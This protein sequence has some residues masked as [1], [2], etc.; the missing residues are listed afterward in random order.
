VSKG[1]TV[2][3]SGYLALSNITTYTGTWNDASIA[4][5]SNVDHAN[6]ADW[7]ASV[8]MGT[9]EVIERKTLATNAASISFLNVDPTYKYLKIIWSGCSSTT[10]NRD[11]QMTLN[12]I[13]VGYQR[14]TSK[15][16]G[17]TNTDSQG[18]NETSMVF[19]SALGGNA[20]Y[21]SGGEI[22][23][24]NPVAAVGRAIRADYAVLTSGS[25][26]ELYQVGGATGGLVTPVNAI[27]LTA[28]ADAIRADSMFT[29]MGM[30]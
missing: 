21:H 6:K 24:T 15:D 13:V 8:G 1:I 16:S 28:S 14:Q 30:K 2:T 17:T 10:T 12:N 4:N 19:L 27:T 11:L 29:L 25:V 5:I 7:A 20:S 9:W 18:S 26:E 22:L 3:G 23:I